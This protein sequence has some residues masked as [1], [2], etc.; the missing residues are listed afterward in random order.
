MKVLIWTLSFVV[1]TVLNVI[2]GYASGF[3]IGSILFYFIWFYSARGMC[4]AWDKH[5]IAKKAEKAGISSFEYIKAE[6]PEMVLANCEENR[7][8]YDSLKENLKGYAKE[9]QITRAYADIL[10]DEY[11]NALK[12]EEIKY[13]V[14]DKAEK[15]VATEQIGFCRKCGEKIIDGSKFCRLCGT[16]V[17]EVICKQDEILHQKEQESFDLESIINAED[18]LKALMEEHAKETIRTMEVNR[19]T[20]PNK[21]E[22]PEFGL[23]PEKPIYTLATD[24]VEGQKAYLNKLR[25]INGEKITWKRL[26]STSAAGIHGM[27]DIYATFLPSGK[28]YKTLFINM[29]GAKKSLGVPQGFAI[30]N[31]IPKTLNP[32]AKVSTS[33]PVPVQQKPVYAKST[34]KVGFWITIVLLAVA[35]GIS[36]FFNYSQYS[37]V[38]SLQNQVA[39]MQRIEENSNDYKKLLSAME[40]VNGMN[41]RI[42]GG[43]I[44]RLPAGYEDTSKIRTQYNELKK[45]ISTIESSTLTTRSCD[46]LRTAYVNLNSF[47]NKYHN[48]DVSD[49]LMNVVYRTH[50]K[51]LIFG[52]EWTD[53]TYNLHWY[54]DGSG[55]RL[56]TNLPNDKKSWKNYYFVSK[57]IENDHIIGYVNVDDTSDRFDAF[58]IVDVICSNG[59]WSISVYCYSNGHTYIL[60]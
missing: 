33:K 4:K 39:E 10:L 19:V 7:G 15:E 28:P 58:K 51:K 22:D 27:I 42:I 47:N 40:N 31:D 3:R 24:I 14:E 53:G 45:Y 1:F 12:L 32:A 60:K 26:G 56:S 55:E 9:D 59:T 2:L 17:V 41:Y 21:E 29:Y 25:T 48:W 20:Q 11:K 8:S 37:Q 35:L 13:V 52:R 5:R 36:L 49:Y 43:L 46:A 54:E 44:D 30:S 16:E 57:K 23:V 38:I 6:I 50:F 34:S 18:P